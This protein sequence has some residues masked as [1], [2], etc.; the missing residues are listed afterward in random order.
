MY[1]YKT[2]NAINED[3]VVSVFRSV[4]WIKNKNDIIAA[5]NASY[6]VTAYDGE[7]L[8]GFARAISDDY[9]YTGIY[10]VVVLPDYQKQGIAK[11]LVKMLIKRFKHTYFFLS[12]TEGNREFY[13][14]CGFVDLPT[15]MW[16]EK[17]SQRILDII[18]NA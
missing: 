11:H 14:R 1:E 17:G 4:G 16:I 8:I 10:D 3:E 2:N 12:Y 15:G 18:S 7:S 13:S 6:Y 5:F 9:Y